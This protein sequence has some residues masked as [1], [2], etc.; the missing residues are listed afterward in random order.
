M[1]IKRAWIG[2]VAATM[3]AMSGSAANG[4]GGVRVGIGIGIPIYN[5]HPYYAYPYPYPYPYY[6]PA[7]YYSYPYYPPPRA[8]YV[9][10]APG[11]A[12][13]RRPIINRRRRTRNG[14]TDL[15]AARAD[16]FGTGGDFATSVAGNRAV[17]PAA[18]A[19]PDAS[20]EPVEWASARSNPCG[21]SGS[22][23]WAEAHTTSHAA[24]SHPCMRGTRRLTFAI[25]FAP[26]PA[27][28]ARR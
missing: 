21:S 17:A 4:G 2:G 24:A 6:Y 16:R 5:P 27:G 23:L 8:V 22:A 9:Q 1:N 25:P 7:P 20:A 3:L 19:R 10:P 18:A 28:C 11:Y 14:R 13:P 12:Q 15:S 26:R